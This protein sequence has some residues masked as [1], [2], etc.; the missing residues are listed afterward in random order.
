MK[1][2]WGHVINESGVDELFAPNTLAPQVLIA[3]EGPTLVEALQEKLDN[4][5]AVIETAHIQDAAI[6]SAKIAEAAIEDAHI[7]IAGISTAKI[8]DL[9]ADILRAVV[10]NIQEVTAGT[11]STNELYA[12]LIMAVSAELKKVT[13]GEGETNRNE[14]TVC[15]GD[16]ICVRGFGKCSGRGSTHPCITG[17]GSGH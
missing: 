12:Q 15:R 9:T 13:A 1:T 11:V 5:F 2:G 4:R 17:G 8:K 6:I 3:E 10:A 16:Q 14:C 7:A